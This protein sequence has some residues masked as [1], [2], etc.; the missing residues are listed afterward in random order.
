MAE[1][2]LSEEDKAVLA[3]DRGEAAKLCLRLVVALA[4][5]RGAPRLL[6]VDSAHVDGCLF[7]GQAGLDFV[8]RLRDLGGR[9]AV[10]TTLNVG[11][12]DLRHP[13][14]VRA[15]PE[16]AA[17][18]RRQMAAYTALGCTPTWT[19]APYQ[20][21]HRPAF[22]THVAWAESNAIVFANSVLG[23]RTD[24]YGDFLDIAAAV[25]G[26]VPDAGLHR[27]EHRRA[28]IRL[29]CAALSPRLLGED[30]AWGVLGHLAGR[31]AGSGVPVLTGVPAA[32]TED[33]LK[34]FGA[35]AASSGGVG[36]FHVVGVTPE[37]PDLA[38]VASPDL[39]VHVVGA[40]QVRA[41]RDELT[42]A[43][44]A[45]IDALCLGTP[46]FSLTEFERLAGLLSGG[47]PLRVR[48]YVTTSRAVLAEAERL[49]HAETVRA[50]GGRIIVDTC[51]YITPIVEPD[52]RTAMTNSGK[53]AW[54]APGN[55]G[56]DVALGS[57]AEC[58]A[59]ARAGRIVRDE[60]LWAG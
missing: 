44:G 26:R 47:E 40:A 25:T 32:V 10:P 1:L 35:A 49:G 30:A 24:R 27:D 17:G 55:I 7:H 23:A 39:P 13:E 60:A 57:L 16:T 3:G 20:L 8:E 12:L 28:T 59:S 14:V 56:V 45:I 58:V 6:A 11:S 4:E 42:T 52:V 18:A 22:G 21:T 29:D 9:V 53:W 50:A 5:V 41:I 51:T 15:D 2:A 43:R 36:L 19:C 31:L 48:A 54:Y 37:A 38:T 46:H 33:Q 34:A